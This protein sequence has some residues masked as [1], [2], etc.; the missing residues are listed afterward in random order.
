MIK[1]IIFDL[2]DTLVDH[3]VGAEAALKAVIDL[4]IKADYIPATY[5]SK[6]FVNAYHKKNLRLWSEFTT[7]RITIDKLLEERFDYISNW[8]ET[9]VKIKE[10]LKKCYWDCYTANC[11]LTADWT[12]LLKKLKNSFS[13]AICSNGSQEVQIRKLKYNNI[14]DFFDGLYFGTRKPECKPFENFFRGIIDDFNLKAEEVLMVG[15]SLDNDII[16]CSKIGMQVLLYKSESYYEE[17][18]EC[19]IKMTGIK[20]VTI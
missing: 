19:I 6:P 7:G 11:P 17:I 18:K 16:P 5:D 15:D 4:M 8:F 3:K 12:P 10:E 14:I 1:L 13:L 9:D 2:D 20:N